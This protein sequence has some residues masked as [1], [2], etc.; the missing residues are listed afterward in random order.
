MR[1]IPNITLVNGILMPQLGLGTYL[2]EG[3][4]GIGTFLD[5]IEIGYRLFDTASLYGNEKELGM[6]LS[7]SKI[8]RDEIFVTSKVW[9]SDQGYD[10]TIKA[11]HGSLN[12]LNLEYM[13]LYL[14][15]WPVKNKWK[16]TWRA[17]EKLYDQDL[18]KAI[19]VSNFYIPHLEQLREIKTIAPMV[20]QIEFHPFCYLSEILQ[21][22]K[23]NKIILQAYAP[24]T[25]GYKVYHPVLKKIAKEYQ[26][27]PAQILLRWGIE[28]EIS[29]IPKAKSSKHLNE[30]HK[31]FDFTLSSRS[32]EE[33]NNLHENFHSDW[34]PSSTL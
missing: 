23:D 25:H 12:R 29:I 13:D 9:N 11:F 24:L 4:S 16:D 8:P 21:Y 15:H 26:K 6:A 22:C 3:K 7:K 2:L 14:I 10:S 34:D 32:I 33:L 20:N 27:T 30:N 19:G 18:C 31:I 17:L 5:A 28:H 1:R